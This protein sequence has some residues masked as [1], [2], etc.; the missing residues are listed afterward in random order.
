MQNLKGNTALHFAHE[1]AHDKI[2]QML[3]EAGANKDLR[4]K[5]GEKPEGARAQSPSTCS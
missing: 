2:K 4:N 3:L 5:S 1:V